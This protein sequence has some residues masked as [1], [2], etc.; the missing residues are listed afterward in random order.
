MHHQESLGFEFKKMNNIIKRYIHA[1]MAQ[2]GFDELTMMHGWI[3]GFIYYHMDKEIYQ[4]DIENNF[5]IAKSTVTNILKLME[6]K[7]Y[8]TRTEGTSDARLKRL[9]LTELGIKVHMD[10]VK[11]IDKLHENMEVG[12]TKEEREVFL[13]VIEKI[14][15]NIGIED[16]EEE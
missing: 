6:K 11:I 1:K 7:G 15:N 13:H 8:L 9:Q 4:K 16:K 10:T 2:Q 14:K 12:I 3:L 5:G